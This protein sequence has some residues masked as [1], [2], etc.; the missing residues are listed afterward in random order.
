MKAA[1]HIALTFLLVQLCAPGARAQSEQPAPAEAPAEWARVEP[2][3]EDFKAQLPGEPAAHPQQVELGTATLAGRLYRL[4]GEDRMRYRVWS[5]K[6]GRAASPQES[7]EFSKHLDDCAELALTLLSGAGTEAEPE[8]GV[9]MSY[10]AEAF[11]PYGMREYR[12]RVGRLRGGVVIFS[13]GE[14]VFAAAAYGPTR[15]AA[16]VERFLDSFGVKPHSAAAFLTRHSR[17]T[18][19]A[20]PARVIG[21]GRGG[22]AAQPEMLTN[23]TGGADYAGP[24]TGQEVARKAVIRSKPEPGYTESARRFGVTGT[25]RLRAAL[26]A[27]GSVGSIYVL[28]WLAHGLTEKAI[29]AARGMRFEPAEKDGRK[30]S[31]W[32]VLEYNFNMY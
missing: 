30:V 24:F 4:D 19:A 16:N 20:F 28:K 13:D 21:P 14:Q 27:D 7:A 3:D 18:P 23:A 25:V 22:G 6:G 8:R 32:V 1:A 2:P 5:L 31:Q 10:A 12:L 29:A 9:V 15:G 26:D 11:L 17:P